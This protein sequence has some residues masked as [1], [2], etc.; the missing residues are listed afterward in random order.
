MKRIKTAIPIILFFICW[1]LNWPVNIET[2]F[3]IANN[4]IKLNIWLVFA[5]GLL[6]GVVIIWI[7]YNI[8]PILIQLFL[9]IEPHL[10]KYWETSFS[11]G[12]KKYKKLVNCVPKNVVLRNQYS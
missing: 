6:A 12:D 10:S 1:K 2:Y 5:I 3:E 4:W 8:M 7:F 11:E 9:G